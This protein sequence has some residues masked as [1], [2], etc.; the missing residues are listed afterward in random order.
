MRSYPSNLRSEY[1]LGLTLPVALVAMLLAMT[2]GFL[3][4]DQPL[5]GL[6]ICGL[7]PITLA[8]F[9]WPEL[10]TLSVVFVLYTNAAVVAVKFHHMPYVLGLLLPLPLAVPL[11]RYLLLRREPFLLTAT[12][13]WILLFSAIQFAS[14]LWASQPRIALNNLV[15]MLVEGMG[16]YLVI[17]NVVRAPETLRRVVWILLAAGAFMGGLSTWQQLSRTHHNNYGGF[18]QIS[19]GPGFT[20]A[21]SQGG[22]TQRRLCGPLGEQNRY[23]QIM[24]ML[25]PLGI[26]RYASETRPLRK[27]AAAV[28][29]GLAAAGAVLTFS[30]GLAI[31][32]AL[33]LVVTTVLGYISARQFFAI[34]VAGFLLLF[35]V[36]SYRTRL[37]SI[38]S[39]VGILKTHG[40][41]LDVPDGAI[42]GR[43]TEMLAAARVF[44]VHPVLGVG[45]GM[46]N[47]LS[48]EFGNLGG[49]RALEGNRE[50]HC[51]YLDLGAEY[52][53][54]GL[55]AF[56][57]MVAVTLRN[58]D[59]TRTQLSEV[60]AEA[61][62]T[63]L[64]FLLALASYLATGLFLHFSYV[65]YF[66]LM[67]ALADVASH[68]YRG[69]IANQAT[70][71][72]ATRL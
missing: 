46:F 22:M 15:P 19:E 33:L 66:W 36:P 44:A 18:A 69:P 67:L 24:F 57:V 14:A 23:A 12:F 60:N 2:A 20:V 48:R 45:P 54:I 32:C 16:L 58:L 11:G 34:A 53:A 64:G 49:F 62:H 25:V 61:R 71:S 51:L 10:A 30:R 31:G 3:L 38:P 4:A 1:W 13:P 41:E 37:A 40:T 68:T 35:A 59:R 5:I 52:G 26:C 43:A 21:T 17:T 8:I 27:S 7:I 42:R 39:A 55:A 63:A 9:R 28:C 65:R 29:T 70:D 50:A 56:L 6:A 72:G 47:S